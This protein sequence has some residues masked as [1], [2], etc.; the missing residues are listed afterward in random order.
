MVKTALS[1]DKHVLDPARLLS[2]DHA[3]ADLRRGAAVGLRHGREAFLVL[4]AETATDE[5]IERLAILSGS[6]PE[7]VITPPRAAA[8]GVSVAEASDAVPAGV[9]LPLARPFRA[10]AIRALADPLAEAEA[11]VMSAAQARGIARHGAHHAALALAKSAR[12]LPAVV[13]AATSPLEDGTVL[14]RRIG[15]AALTHVNADDAFRH[16]HE[17]ARN[18]RP[19]GEARVPLEGAEETRIVAFRPND[20]GAEHLAIVI[21]TPDTNAPVL[22]RL[23]SECLTGDL[24]GSLR[25]D[26][27]PQLRGAIRE[28]AAQGAGI[29]LYLAQE[30]RGIGLVNKLRAYRL[31]DEGYDTFDANER[32]GYEADERLYI[33]A[34]EMLKLL[35][36]RRVR[37]MTNNPEKMARLAEHGIEVTERVAHVFP[38][39]PHNERYLRTKAAKGGHLID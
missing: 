3:I 12:L 25:C 5:G 21:G 6:L 20:G 9:R 14:P 29:V 39:N 18:L 36:V 27:G 24:L 31:Q 13:M 4:A 23:H 10:E 38:S 32:L 17:I 30:G 26:C 7:L 37:L 2:V 34:A 22:V 1:R 8:L 28:I 19:V 35:S 33:V 15:E 11:A 16:E